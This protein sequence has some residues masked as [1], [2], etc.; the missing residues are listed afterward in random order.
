MA[1][2]AEQG[3]LRSVGQERE[4]AGRAVEAMQTLDDIERQARPFSLIPFRSRH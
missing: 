4:A 2:R 3:T 1:A